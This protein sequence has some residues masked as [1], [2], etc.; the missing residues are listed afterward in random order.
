M[1]VAWRGILAG[2]VLACTTA[3]AG[4]HAGG[5][6]GGGLTGVD[7]FNDGH[8]PAGRATTLRLDTSLFVDLTPWLGGGA[9]L[10]YSVMFADSL[11]F[12][13]GHVVEPELLLRARFAFGPHDEH[14]VSVTAGLGVGLAIYGTPSPLAGQALHAY[15]TMASVRLGYAH[16]VRPRISWTVGLDLR[17]TV[18]L[19]EMRFQEDVDYWRNARHFLATATLGAGVEYEL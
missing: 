12:D 16:R 18:P 17:A 14:A 9:G 6:I 1:R 13:T 15:G 10:A 4:T 7:T 5:A 19:I 3:V 2:L 8:G 11:T